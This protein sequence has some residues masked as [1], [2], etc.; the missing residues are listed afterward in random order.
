[1]KL[2]FL[3]YVFNRFPLEYCFQIAQAYGFEGVEIWGARPHGYAYDMD[4]E[5]IGDVLK[6]K[7]QYGQ[8]ISM[9][10]PEILAYPYGFSSRLA[11]ERQETLAYLFKGV[12]TAAAIGTERMQVTVPHPGY[13]RDKE[14]VW[15]QTAAGLKALSKRAG[16]LGVKVVLEQLTYSEGGNLL[17]TADDL[18]KMLREVNEPALVSMLDNV[19]TFVANEPFSECFAKLGDKIDYVH[20]GNSDAYSE[21]H[22]RLDEYDGQIP[23]ADFFSVLKRVGYQGWVSM[24]MQ[25]P[26]FKDPEL[27]IAGTMRILSD[28]FRQ[29]ESAGLSA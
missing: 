23:L 5:A 17:S 3:S 18:V 19:P 15:T 6:W 29:V 16:E 22:L 12:E 25:A 2:S 13:M 1:M 27:Y 9:Y 7:K 14:E 20:I 28:I 4:A 26:Y 10:S 24:E 21:V 11:K 8:E